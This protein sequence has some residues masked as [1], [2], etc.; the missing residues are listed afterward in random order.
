MAF[1][2]E[3]K[4]HPILIQD[5]NFR[6]NTSKL[7]KVRD[8]TME[9][10]TNGLSFDLLKKRWNVFSENRILSHAHFWSLFRWNITERCCGSLNWMIH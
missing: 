1:I 5:G 3:Q 9:E 7:E 4:M 6:H 2:L 8:E 10:T